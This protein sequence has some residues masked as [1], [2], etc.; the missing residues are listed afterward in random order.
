[1]KNKI[2]IEQHKM[3][4]DHLKDNDVFN[5]FSISIFFK[6]KQNRKIKRFENKKIFFFFW[7]KLEVLRH[8]KEWH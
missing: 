7:V 2:K 6:L 5:I 8:L 4:Q 1:M 3:M